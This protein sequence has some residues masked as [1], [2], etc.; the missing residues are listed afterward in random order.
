MGYNAG[1]AGN[2]GHQILT[3]NGSSTLTNAGD[4]NLGES[5]GALAEVFLNDNAVLSSDWRLFVGWHGSATGAVVLADSSVMTVDAWLSI[6]D[7]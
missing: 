7:G 3:L 6:E 1:I 2:L 5:Q 4:F